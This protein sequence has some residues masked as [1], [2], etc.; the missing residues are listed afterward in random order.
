M[1]AQSPSPAPPPAPEAGFLEAL[2]QEPALLEV[3]VVMFVL[4]LFLL[5]MWRASHIAE[6][7]R[8]RA[9]LEDYLLGV[10]QA[11][12]GDLAGAGKRLRRVLKEAPDNQAARLLYGEVL[13]E[14]GEPAQAH[15]HH[16]ELQ[17]AFRLE[18]PRNDMA[19]A[20]SLLAAGH[21]E[22]AVEPAAAAARQLPWGGRVSST[23][24]LRSWPRRS[25][26]W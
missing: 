8:S 1:L 3:G 7:A 2:A 11:L 15:K 24:L 12:A 6:T 5:I 4:G 14:L 17:R 25:T 21:P 9:A 13:A 22:L 20:R 23:T 16:L 19:K 18:S 26:R 10:E